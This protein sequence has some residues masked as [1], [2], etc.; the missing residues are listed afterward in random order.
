MTYLNNYQSYSDGILELSFS[1]RETKLI[2]LTEDSGRIVT[3]KKVGTISNLNHPGINVG[4]EIGTNEIFILHNHYKIFK[5][6]GV[7][8]YSEYAAG[9]KVNWDNR[10]CVNNKMLVLQN[11]LDQAIKREKYHWL[12][13]NCQIT[14]NDACNNKRT[15]EDVAKWGGRIA[16]GG[17]FLFILNAIF[18]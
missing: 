7:S 13:N 3:R 16:A 17:L 1:N 5:T 14:V 4:N 18:E 10:V 6:A 11:G 8:P 12:T 9:E 2:R 15:S